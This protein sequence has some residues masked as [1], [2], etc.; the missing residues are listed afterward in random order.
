MRCYQLVIVAI[1]D[2]TFRVGDS[3]FMIGS[4]SDDLWECLYVL[5]KYE[6]KDSMYILKRETCLNKGT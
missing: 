4:T 6:G 3:L 1:K 5:C 2:A